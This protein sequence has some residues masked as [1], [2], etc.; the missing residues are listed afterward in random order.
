MLVRFELFRIWCEVWGSTFILSAV[1]L[2][3]SQN[4]LLK[5]LFFP[6]RTD[7]GT[8]V[9]DQW[10]WACACAASVQSLCVH[11]YARITVL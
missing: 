4:L 3:L 8:L 2:R 1:A 11:P 7:S 10:A 9:S 5:G 6:H